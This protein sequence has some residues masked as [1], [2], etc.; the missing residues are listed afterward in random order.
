MNNFIIYERN[1]F[2]YIK[3]FIGLLKIY[4]ADVIEKYNEQLNKEK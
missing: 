2:K 3:Y 4:I 1:L